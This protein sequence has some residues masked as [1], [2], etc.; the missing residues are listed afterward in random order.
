MSSANLPTVHRKSTNKSVCFRRPKSI[1]FQ[2][3]GKHRDKLQVFFLK[4][5][6]VDISVDKR[7]D[8][9][10]NA[11]R[12]CVKISAQHKCQFLVGAHIACTDLFTGQPTVCKRDKTKQLDENH[13]HPSI[14]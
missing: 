8:T 13:F 9:T 3:N 11:H 14:N 12:N 1:V 10:H 2:S 4:S 6:P 7:L 5:A